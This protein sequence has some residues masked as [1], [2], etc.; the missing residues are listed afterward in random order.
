[1]G[2]FVFGVARD[3]TDRLALEAEMLAAREA[4][5]AANRT[6]SDFLANMSH[7]IRTPLNGVIGLVDALGRTELKADQRDMV[8]L[9]RTRRGHAWERLLSRY[10]RPRPGSTRRACCSVETRTFD[11]AAALTAVSD[12]LAC[13]PSRRDLAFSLQKV[14]AGRRGL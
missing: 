14:Q 12:L 10:P 9:I 8:E 13:A 6:K 1:M 5:E 3:V 11:L 2:E 4:A 7:E